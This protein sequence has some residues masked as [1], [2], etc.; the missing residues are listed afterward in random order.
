MSEFQTV[1]SSH[2][3]EWQ[4]KNEDD[5]EEWLP[6]PKDQELLP[7]PSQIESVHERTS[8]LEPLQGAEFQ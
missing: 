1:L 7:S 8:K 6:S 5:E 4:T 3:P 2:S